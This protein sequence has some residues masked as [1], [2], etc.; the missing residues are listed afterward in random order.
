MRGMLGIAAVAVAATL[1]AAPAKS[2]AQVSVG[3]NIGPAPV[4]QYGYYGFAPYR[5][6]PYGYYGPEWFG[7]GRFVGAGP[8][9]RG[10][11]PF[12]GSVNRT[13]DPRFGYHGAY[14][15]YGHQYAPPPDHFQ[16]FH[17]NAY[18]DH[19]GYEAPHEGY[20]PH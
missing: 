5:C 11:H 15:A 12:Y 16:N 1:F 4:C 18:H 7:G 20:R 19:N 2:H 14:P 3:I 10:D 13:Y 6:A 8:W 17:G 9:Y